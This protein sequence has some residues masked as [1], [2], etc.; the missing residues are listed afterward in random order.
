MAAVK[1]VKPYRDAC[2]FKSLGKSL[3]LIDRCTIIIDVATAILDGEAVVLDQEG[4][5][6]FRALQQSLGGRGARLPFDAILYASDPLYFDGHDISGMELSSR[7]HLL[8]SL[9]HGDDSAIRFSETVEGS[10][11]Q[12]F[13]AACSHCLEGIIAKDET[14][15]IGLDARATG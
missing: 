7:R 3:S 13:E 6:D 10:G 8:E 14:A 1:R 11:K 5:P 9:V 12:I 2:T 4:R 15:P